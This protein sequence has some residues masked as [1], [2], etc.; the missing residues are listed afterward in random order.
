MDQRSPNLLQCFPWDYHR[1]CIRPWLFVGILYS[2]EHTNNYSHFLPVT[3]WFYR[4][5]PSMHLHVSS[6]DMRL[7]FLPSE[8]LRSAVFMLSLSHEN[9]FYQA[10]ITFL[11]STSP[12]TLYYI[13]CFWQTASLSSEISYIPSLSCE[14]TNVPWLWSDWPRCTAMGL[15]THYFKRKRPLVLGLTSSGAAMGR[16]IDI[17]NFISLLISSLS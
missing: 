4:A 8:P 14:Y 7:H 6:S 13:R 5:Q 17:Q 10:R 12:K 15:P 2:F 9:S 1:S 11:V 3:I 16:L